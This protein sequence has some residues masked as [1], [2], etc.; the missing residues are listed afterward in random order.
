MGEMDV[1]QESANRLL[2]NDDETGTG[3]YISTPNG[4]NCTAVVSRNSNKVSSQSIG[5]VQ[6]QKSLVDSHP[7]VARSSQTSRAGGERQMLDGFANTSNTSTRPITQSGYQSLPAAQEAAGGD[8]EGEEML[9][10][11]TQILRNQ[12][13]INTNESQE[14]KAKYQKSDDNRSEI[15]EVRQRHEEVDEKL[16]EL[17]YYQTNELKLGGSLQRDEFHATGVGLSTSNQEATGIDSFPSQSNDSAFD[18]EKELKKNQRKWQ[19][20]HKLNNL[21]SNEIKIRE[22]F[23]QKVYPDDATPRGHPNHG[24]LFDT[25][26]TNAGTVISGASGNNQSGANRHVW[27]RES[28][29]PNTASNQLNQQ[30]RPVSGGRT[31]K[32]QDMSSSIVSNAMLVL[33]NKTSDWTREEDRSQRVASRGQ[34]R[35]GGRLN[36]SLHASSTAAWPTASPKRGSTMSNATSFENT[37]SN[38]QT[39]RNILSS[40]R[41]GRP[42]SRQVDDYD[43]YSEFGL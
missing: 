26:V 13:G 41:G 14:R 7:K 15:Q 34:S 19:L 17:L 16:N 32:S 18:I 24:P 12:L 8:Q 4:S 40:S 10:R 25:I 29:R 42:G 11:R 43:L 21:Q 28:S 6:S 20:I 35:G 38:P 2:S 5:A 1:H 36:D 27:S 39:G 30:T 31:R 3:S 22:I 9:P 33:D 37:L 23:E